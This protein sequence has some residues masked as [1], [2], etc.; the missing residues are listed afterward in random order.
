M[1]FAALEPNGLAAFALVRSLITHLEDRR[2][3]NGDDVELICAGALER[4]ATL[5]APSV[6]LVLDIVEQQAS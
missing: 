6:Q 5:T 4:L 2:V 1:S 3:L